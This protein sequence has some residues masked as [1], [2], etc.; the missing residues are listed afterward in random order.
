MTDQSNRF[1]VEDALDDDNSVVRLSSE[2]MEKLQLFCGDAAKFKGRK[3][4]QTV[5]LVLSDDSCQH[6]RIRMNKVMQHNLRVQSGDIVTFQECQHVNYGK[7]VYI[8]PYADLLSDI[9]DDML[10]EHLQSYFRDAY[11]PVYIGDTFNRQIGTNTVEFK[12]IE[13]DPNPYCIVAPETVIDYKGEPIS[14]IEEQYS[15]NEVDFLDVAGYDDIKKCLQES[16]QGILNFQNT[17]HKFLTFGLRFPTGILLYGPPGCGKTMLAKALA[18]ECDINLLVLKGLEL[19]ATRWDTAEVNLR[20]AFD[21]A[22]QTAPCILLI[23]ELDYVFENQTMD[24]ITNQLL[25]EIDGLTPQSQVILIATTNRPELFHQTFLRPGRLDEKVFVPLPDQKAR[26]TIINITLKSYSEMTGADIISI[27]Q[28]L[29]GATG[30]DVVEFC[31]RA[32]KIAIREMVENE[33][34][35]ERLNPDIHSDVCIRR[36]HFEQIWRTLP[37][38]CLS[39]DEYKKYEVFTQKWQPFERFN[40]LFPKSADNPEGKQASKTYADDDDLYG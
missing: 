11:R 39:N 5:S 26:E 2:T 19:V 38:L 25:T 30:A 22:R 17:N 20:A 12:V 37:R 9:T 33:S 31:Q 15:S 28:A 7:R 35:K 13:T 29:Q 34:Q 32:C 10:N 23:D 4:R 36:D 24:H 40:F 16:V 1:I 18:N 8:L 27:A 6:D 14:R 3:R 21:K